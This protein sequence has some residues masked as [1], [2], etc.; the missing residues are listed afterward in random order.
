MVLA[1]D[2][3]AR[4]P[5]AASYVRQRKIELPGVA[6]EAA[7]GGLSACPFAGRFPHRVE[8]VCATSHRTRKPLERQESTGTETAL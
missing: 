2:V 8:P 7:G 6:L 3:R 4:R 5:S 1:S